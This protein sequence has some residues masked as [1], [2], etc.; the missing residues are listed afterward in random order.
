DVYLTTKAGD[1]GRRAPV[2]AEHFQRDVALQ[3]PVV[4]QVDD[5][6]AAEAEDF[7][8]FIASGEVSAG[9]KQ[10]RSNAGEVSISDALRREVPHRSRWWNSGRNRTPEWRV[11]TAKRT[12]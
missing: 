1:R 3:L 8:D 6:V 11:L 7:S 4:G 2:A 9:W 12:V 5:G 10:V